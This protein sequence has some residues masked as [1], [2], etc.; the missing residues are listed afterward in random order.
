MADAAGPHPADRENAK[1][2][3]VEGFDF[4]RRGTPLPF[5]ESPRLHY[6]RFHRWSQ[7]EGWKVANPSNVTNWRRGTPLPFGEAPRLH[8][9]RSHHRSQSEAWKVA[10][11]SNATSWRRS[12]D[13]RLF[14]H[15]R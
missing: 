13:M 1:A 14:V 10:N 7:S 6:V 4:R 3:R 8:Y 15:G 12:R 9:V 2:L 11:P 5:G